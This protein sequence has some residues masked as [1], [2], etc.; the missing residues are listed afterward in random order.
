MLGGGG[1][2]GGGGTRTDGPDMSTA[3]QSTRQAVPA[4]L[5]AKSNR[6]T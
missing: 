2:G 3:V 4:I 6:Q 5:T 1:G